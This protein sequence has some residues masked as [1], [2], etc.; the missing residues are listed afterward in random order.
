MSFPCSD[1]QDDVLVGI[2]DVEEDEN[3]AADNISELP[4]SLNWI[5]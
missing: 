2:N 5:S 3:K 4:K 1:T